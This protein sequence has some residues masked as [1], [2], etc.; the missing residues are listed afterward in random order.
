MLNRDFSGA[1]AIKSIEINPRKIK[2][3]MQIND[4]GVCEK[5]NFSLNYISL[6]L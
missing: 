5:K 4:F 6:P 1:S 2:D 3:S